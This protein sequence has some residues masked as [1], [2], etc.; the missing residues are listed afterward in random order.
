MD[1]KPNQN[2][3]ALYLTR[4]GAGSG[5]HVAILSTNVPEWIRVCCPAANQGA[6]LA[7]INPPRRTT[8]AAHTQRLAGE[9]TPSRESQSRRRNCGAVRPPIESFYGQG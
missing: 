3:L 4:G 8:E 2:M 7:T 5:Y 1:H 9:S 6:A